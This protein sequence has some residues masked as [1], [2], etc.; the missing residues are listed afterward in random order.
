MFLRP[1]AVM[2]LVLLSACGPGPLR[3]TVPP[4][5]LG[6]PVAVSFATVEVRD[7]SLPT[8]AEDDEILVQGAGGSLTPSG[9][10]WADDPVRAITLE[11]ASALNALTSAQVVPE[12]WPFEED[13]QA[14]LDVRMTEIVADAAT[15]TFVMRGDYF[16]G[17]FDGTGRDRSGSFRIA[18]PLPAGSGPTAIPAARA[19]AVALLAREIALGGLR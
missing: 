8:Y 11:L 5:P 9:G 12:P 16:V 6:E 4:T 14:R 3:L 10:V 17:S 18:V 19:Q 15:S 2:G 1:F 13:A 7:V